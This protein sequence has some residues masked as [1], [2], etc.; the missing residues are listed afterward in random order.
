MNIDLMKKL[1]LGT[2][3]FGTSYGISNSIGVPND[4]EL[5]SIFDIANTH[6]IKILDSAPAYGNAQHR[7]G[8]YAS[9]RFEVVSK[10]LNVQSRESLSTVIQQSLY[11]L[12]TSKLYAL[13]SH[14]SD[15]L[16][17]NPDLWNF[18]SEEKERGQIERIGY[19]LYTPEQLQ[20]LLDLGML[21]DIVQLP[22]N[23]LDRKFQPYF[24]ELK[25][26]GTEIHI[27]SVFL[28]GLFFLDVKKLSAKLDPIKP[29]LTLIHN[30]CR[31]SKIPVSELA[32]GFVKNNPFIDKVLIGVASSD[33][34]S[35]NIHEFSLNRVD[36]KLFEQINNIKIFDDTILNPATWL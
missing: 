5:R 31:E 18:L 15:E 23:L 2:V 36:N 30:L 7:I 3:Q 29:A 32:L 26:F 16:I 25:R 8:K 24:G 33:Q 12:N 10:F 22:F 1:A 9:N 14:N 6:G 35:K 17:A 34:L 21:P 19:S 4:D 28:Q 27:R 11:D 20:K 13:I